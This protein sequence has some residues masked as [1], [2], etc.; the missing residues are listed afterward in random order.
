LSKPVL[1]NARCDVLRGQARRS[2]GGLWYDGYAE[3]R[4]SLRL[5]L[6]DAALRA[7]L[8][9]AGRAFVDREYAWPVIE[10]KYRELAERVFPR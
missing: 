10:A 7:R 3:F 8:G 6:D 2:G 5:L 1:V 4:E 9:A